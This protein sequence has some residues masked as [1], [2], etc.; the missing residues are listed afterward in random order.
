M[1]GV[2][3]PTT[4]AGA[5]AVGNAEILAGIVINQVLEPGRPVI[6]NLGLAHVFDMRASIAVTGA[7]ENHLLAGL[8]AAMGRFYNLP[9]C[10]WVSTE[11]M[12]TDSQAAMEKTAGF[13]SHLQS[14]NNL[15]WGV[16]QLESE[17]TV[18]PAQAVIDNEIL[19]Y[20][21]RY[22]R[23][24]EVDEDTLALDVSRD[25]GIAGSFLA[26]EHT[27]RHCRSEFFEPALLYRGRRADWT[28]GGS[29]SLHERAEEKAE[30]LM[31]QTVSSGLTEDQTAE[32]RRIEESFA[33]QAK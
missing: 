19:A 31:A 33:S 14:G 25:V 8:G 16:G 27:L 20:V 1:A 24:V 7:P 26:E 15:V 12:A 5:A 32:L 17:L 13:L 9:S 28:D 3:G 30:R 6:H 18:S 11:S 10:S 23:G 22:L 4:L 29:R 2:S 21:R